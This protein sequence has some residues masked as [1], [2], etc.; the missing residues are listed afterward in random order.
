MLMRPQIRGFF[1][2]AT[3]TITYLAADPA[4]GEAAIIDP[5]LAFD[6]AAGRTSP[7]LADDVL[8][9]AEEAGLC[10]TW[11]L[12]THAHADHL[13]AAKLIA[14]RT[15]AKIGIGAGIAAV[16]TRFAPLLGVASEEATTAVFD[17]LFEDG[18]T[19]ALGALT[20]RVIATPGHTPACVSYLVGDAVFVGDT[21][22]MPDFGT[23]R[24]DFPGGDARTLYRSIQKLLALPDETR[25]YVGHDYPPPKRQVPSFETTVGAQKR[26]NVHVGGGATEDAFVAMRDARDAQLGLPK[27]MIPS[28][29]VNIRGGTAPRPEADGRSYLK[30]P[31]DAS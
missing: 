1:D 16:Q 11:V 25:M 10:V 18:E 9:A 14:A 3:H 24:A 21:L 12:E 23:A 29:Q 27:L 7:H 6:A 5:V 26:S 19:F 2:E 22:F 31:F 20:V 4:T 15:G 8:A 17:R 13:T 28:L 30:I